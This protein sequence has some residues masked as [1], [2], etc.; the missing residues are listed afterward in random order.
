MIRNCLLGAT[1]MP[2]SI[3]ASYDSRELRSVL[4]VRI[5]RL[6]C[7][8]FSVFRSSG[9]TGQR[10]RFRIIAHVNRAFRAL[11]LARFI[12][13]AHHHFI[14][15]LRSALNFQ[16]SNFRLPISNFQLPTFNFRLSTPR[17]SKLEV[18]LQE[19]RFRPLGRGCGL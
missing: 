3:R 17:S 16:V 10:R 18:E 7:I 9:A 19:L 5:S 6:A 4:F 15:L 13:R 1:S 12:A 14:A 8:T 2:A 11:F